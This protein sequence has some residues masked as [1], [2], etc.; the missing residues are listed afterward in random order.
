[1]EKIFEPPME[2]TK[3]GLERWVPPQPGGPLDA[4]VVDEDGDGGQP[5]QAVGQPQPVARLPQC[6]RRR[7]VVPMRLPVDGMWKENL[8]FHA[9]YWTDVKVAIIQQHKS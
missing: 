1:M 9:N 6:V 4:Q 8:D 7:R 2:R 5:L 3:S